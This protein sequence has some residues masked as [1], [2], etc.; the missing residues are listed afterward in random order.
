MQSAPRFRP[1]L[2]VLTALACLAVAAC[3]E[4]SSSPESGPRE[5]SSEGAGTGYPAALEKNFLSSCSLNA[6]AASSGNLSRDEARA[7]CQE[8][9]ECMQPHLTAAEIKETERRML[10]GERNPGAKVL[11]T[12]MEQTVERA[13]GS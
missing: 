1:G 5:L 7:L 9:L 10:S 6:A 8:V 2:W 11:R 12:C 13:K 4:S 3:G